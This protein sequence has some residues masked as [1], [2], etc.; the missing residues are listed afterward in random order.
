MHFLPTLGCINGRLLTRETS[1]V[2]LFGLAGLFWCSTKTDN[3][4]HLGHWLA[5][6]CSGSTKRSGSGAV[7]RRTGRAKFAVSAERFESRLVLSAPNPFSLS[8]LD[9]MNGFK[10]NGLGVRAE[11]GYSISDAGD[12]NGDGFGDVIIGA[13]GSS[14]LPPE[15]PGDAYVVFG[16]ASGIPAE[17]ELSQLN[18]TDGFRLAGIDADDECGRSVSGAGDINGDGIDDVIVGAVHAD[19]NGGSSG[20]SY[21][22]FGK[23]GAFAASIELSTLNGRN[24]FRLDGIWAGDATGRAVSNAGDV[25]GDGFDDLIIGAHYADIDNQSDVGEVYVVFGKPDGFDAVINFS[26]LN[27]VN[28][29][30]LQ[31]VGLGDHTGNAVSN[32]GDVNGDGFGDVIVGARQSGQG[33][34]GEDLNLPGKGYVVFGKSSGFAAILDLDNLD[35]VNGFRLDGFHAHDRLGQSVSGAGDINGDGFDDVIIGAQYAEPNGQRSGEG[36]VVFGKSS[37]FASAIDLNALIGIDGFQIEGSDALHQLGVSVSAAGDVNADGFDDLIVGAHNAPFGGLSRAGLSYILFGKA[38]GFGAVFD[39]GTLNGLNGFQIGGIDAD[40]VS[41]RTVSTAGDVNGDGFDDVII[42]ATDA[43]AGAEDTH[44]GEGYV[45]FGGNFTGG[46]ETQVGG[47]SADTLTATRGANAVDILVGGLGNDTLVSDGGSDVLRGGTGDD[48]L[49]IPDTNFSSTRRLVGGRGVDTLR[50]DGAGLAL[51]L[52]TISDNRISE[53]E[54]IDIRGSG[55]NMLTLDYQEVV[56]IS[57]ETNTLLVQRDLND[58]VNM[59]SGWT[60]FTL[61]K[62]GVRYDAFRQGAATLLLTSSSQA[63]SSPVTIQVVQGRLEIDDTSNGAINVTIRQEL[64]PGQVVVTVIDANSVAFEQQVPV[65]S[66]SAGVLTRL[67]SGNDKLDLSKLDLIATVFGGAGND[68]LQGS[69]QADVLKGEDGDDT[70]RGNAGNDQLDGG[71]GTDQLAENI[72][73][74]AA[75]NVT[76]T[77]NQLTIVDSGVDSL[78]G[79]ENILIS[80]GGAASRIDASLASV[81]VSLFGGGGADTLIGSALADTLNGQGGDDV[82][83]GQ[84]GADLLVGGAGTDTLKEAIDQNLT[85]T[86]AALTAAGNSKAT[87]VDTLATIEKVDLTGGVSRNRID[88]SGFTASLGATISGGGQSDSIIGSPGPDLIMTLTGADSVLGLA[89]SDTMFTGSGN[90]TLDGGEGNDSLNGQN[91]DDSLLGNAGNDVLTGGA[92]LDTLTGGAD[93]DFLSGQTDAGLLN[94]GTGNDTLQGNTASD[95]LNG[96]AGDDRLYGLQSNDELNGGDGADSLLGGIGDD[97]LRGGAG[98]DTLSGE[99]GSDVL[100]GG[101]DFDRINELLDTN[102]TIT[103]INLSSS[104]LGI[105]AFIAIERIQLV[106][107]PSNNF[108]DARAANV[109]LLLS[110]AAGNDTLLGGTRADGIDGGDGDDVLLGGAG[111]D[112]ISGGAGFDYWWEKADSDFTVSGVTIA[113]TTTGSEASTGIERIVVIGGPGNN[114]INAITSSLPVVLIGGKGNDNL[115]GGSQADVLSG[116][117]RNDATV[118]GGDGVDTLNGGAADDIYESDVTDT[119]IASLGNDSTIPDVFI[120]LPDWVDAI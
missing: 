81:P 108:F 98:A 65:A 112:V 99:V 115:I 45:V 26:T 7:V 111:A 100:D 8:S 11:A 22:V 68:S 93:N 43:D 64:G 61:V 77:T 27:G 92:G 102:F 51:D 25:N 23:R 57:G 103:G 32:A 116:G 34:S 37:G 52:T 69:S 106:G 76:I 83:T 41:G 109:P 18:G 5:A 44:D 71:I 73:T 16:K 4:M 29:F 47:P 120:L 62:D 2:T 118:I 58:A 87:G 24:G 72:G 53:V 14:F 78:A 39:P 55:S 114:T 31:G 21:V 110:G 75:A 49:A 107:G 119:L 20:E 90:D 56:N 17:I 96:D 3:F 60:P 117:N 1:A 91:G 50:F 67:N 74:N 38:S 88:L 84:G 70:L 104:V 79:L 101:D 54:V 28:G 113:S 42:S 19:P 105:D 46:A 13:P 80:D 95:T 40:D 89:G 15:T 97:S 48:T 35:G 66:V 33:D 82:L 94:G 6:L 12:V 9:G 10:L 63:P 36:Y 85:L 86:N 59:G 30:R